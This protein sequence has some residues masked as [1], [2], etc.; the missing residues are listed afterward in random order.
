MVKI[1][2]LLVTIDFPDNTSFEYTGMDTAEYILSVYTN[3][4]VPA[5]NNN[6]YTYYE[7]SVKDQNESKLRFYNFSYRLDNLEGYAL[8][9]YPFVVDMSNNK[10]VGWHKNYNK[11]L[12]YQLFQLRTI[13]L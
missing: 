3:T 7:I 10:I 12:I 5:L 6:N 8:N 11:I 2:D 13:L 9:G 1:N 4:D